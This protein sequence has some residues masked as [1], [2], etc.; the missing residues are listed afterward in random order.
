M[1]DLD[2]SAIEK[3]LGVEPSSIAEMPEEIRTKMKTVLETI[4]VRTDEDRK[5]LYNALDLLWQKGSVLVTLEKVSKAT[6][7]PFLTLSNLDFETQ[8]VIVFEYLANSG[9]TKQIYMLTNSA[10]AVIE[11]DKIAKLIAVPVRELRKLPRRIQEQM[12]GAYATGRRSVTW[13]KQKNVRYSR[14]T[15]PKS[16]RLYILQILS[17]D[18][19]FSRVTKII[20]TRLILRTKRKSAQGLFQEKSF[21]VRRK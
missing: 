7:I 9:N 2:Y 20:G 11:L 14:T 17:T 8:Q 15:L 4:V 21:A 13:K 5:E 1:N 6:G 12:C 3:A 10:L 18:R 16:V 19:M